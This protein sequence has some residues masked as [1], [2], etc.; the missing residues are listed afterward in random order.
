MPVVGIRISQEDK[1]K[2]D[3][4]AHILGTNTSEIIR[5]YVVFLGEVSSTLKAIKT[6]EDVSKITAKAII[7]NEKVQ[8][9][10]KQLYEYLSHDLRSQ[11][12]LGN[13]NNCYLVPIMSKYLIAKTQEGFSIIKEISGKWYN[14]YYY[15]VNEWVD[16]DIIDIA[17]ILEYLKETLYH[18]MKTYIESMRKALKQIMGGR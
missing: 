15:I 10:L 6:L 18:D 3:F 5:K 16:I 7:S 17:D 1:Q 13:I 9:L 14:E 11:Y 12:C 8:K 4:L 2:L